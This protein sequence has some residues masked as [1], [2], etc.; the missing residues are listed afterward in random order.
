MSLTKV[1]NAMIRSAPVNV[2]DY[3][4]ASQISDVQAY[5][6]GVDVTSACQAALDAA[7]ANNLDCYFPAGG[8]LVTGLTI[9]GDVNP[10]VDD[11]KSAI[12]IY[13]QGY[14]EPFV[15]TNTG[16]T[17]IKSVTDAPVLKDLLGTAQSSNGTIEIDHIRLDG[18]STTA[19][20]K[21][22]SFY[23]LSSIHNLVVYQRGTG[24]GIDITY[25]AT[26]L[27]Q[28][29]YAMNSDWATPTKGSSRTGIG[30][31]MP[32]V[33][34]SGLQTFYKCTARGWL[35]GFELGVNTGAPYTPQIEQCEC[36]TV[37]N[38]IILYGTRKAVIDSNYFEGGDGGKGIYIEG[39]YTTVSNNMM[40]S[41]FAVGIDDRYA[42]NVGTTITGNT[43]GIG[44]F[45][46]A[47]AIATAGEYGKS[48]TGNTII[49]T[50]GTALQVGIYV[51]SASSKLLIAGNTFDPVSTWTGTSA[52]KIAYTATT[53]PSGLIIQEDTSTD[54]PVLLDGAIALHKNSTTLTASNVSSNILTVPDGSYFLVT[55]GSATTVNQLSTGANNGRIIVF[56]TTN[57]NMTFADTSYMFLNGSF[58]GPG[59]LT[60]LVEYVAGSNYAYEI[61]RTTF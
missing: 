2:F 32:L 21:L 13:G 14:G 34:D 27:V 39:N 29:I 60:L 6:F 10:P 38:G 5:T 41:G 24:N 4:I 58:T 26:F 3:M 52:S 12:R 59:T 17:V 43:V 49:R 57:A 23:G 31:N 56:R 30:F 51:D 53:I 40:F 28:Q 1:T 20:L 61:A 44:D 7:R 19:V 11:R 33:S 50:A 47:Y 22:E 54:F 42:S 46:N 37:Y 55:A 25:G 48:I 8:Y 16:G 15:Q 45:V 9:P 36:S 18:T 35:T